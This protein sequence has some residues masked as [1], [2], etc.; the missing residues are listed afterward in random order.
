MTINQV[1]VYTVNAFT[2]QGK[3]GNPAGVVPDADSLSSQQ[4]QDIARQMGYPETAFVC[5]PEQDSAAN[6]KVRFYTNRRSG[7]LWP[8]HTGDLQPAVEATNTLCRQLYTGHRCRP[9][10]SQHHRKRSGIHGSATS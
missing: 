1:Q 5:S 7:F 9:S 8:C 3:G 4:M 2:Y 10:E 6:L